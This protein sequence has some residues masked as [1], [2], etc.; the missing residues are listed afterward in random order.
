MFVYLRV[1]LGEGEADLNRGQVTRPDSNSNKTQGRMRPLG[2]T[3]A[4]TWEIKP[5]KDLKDKYFGMLC[6]CEILQWWHIRFPLL[7]VPQTSLHY[8]LYQ[9]EFCL[10]IV[11]VTLIYFSSDVNLIRNP[12]RL[13]VYCMTPPQMHQFKSWHPWLNLICRGD[14]EPPRFS[15]LS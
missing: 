11:C 6:Q 13:F 14:E 3:T 8:L 15:F 5:Q 12:A 1:H 4:P 9:W 2:Q 10:Y 7:S